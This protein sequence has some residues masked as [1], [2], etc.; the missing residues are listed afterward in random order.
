MSVHILIA[1]DHAIVRQGI[2]LMIKELMLPA[3]VIQAQDYPEL[4]AALHSAPKIDLLLCDI[5]M[6]GG[7]SFKISE[8]A[9]AIHPN[10]KTLIFSAYSEDLYAL[11][12]IQ[13]GA[14]GFLHKDASEEEIKHAIISVLQTGKYVSR[15]LSE[16]VITQLFSNDAIVPN[17]P[18]A[19][20]SNREMEV[21]GLLVK[22]LGLLEISNQLNIRVST[23]ST[24]K[25]RLYEKLKITNIAELIS[26]YNT[27]AER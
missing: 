10:I 8:T 25:T 26:I 19:L 4:I 18:L 12:Y 16:S 21:A 2:L 20:L 22:G 23:I 1:D 11:R 13:S 7:D 9:K 3:T 24:Y 5:N 6:P 17:N 15:H 14:N 27:Y